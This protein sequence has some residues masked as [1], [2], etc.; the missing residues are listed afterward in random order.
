MLS[1]I[2]RGFTL[3]EL[4]VVIVIL[5]I[6]SVTALPKFINLNQEAER[7]VFESYY[8]A[9]K[10]AVKMYSLSW[11]AKGQPSS[12]FNGFSS[13]PSATGYPAGG[14]NL[15]TVFESDCITIWS[16]LIQGSPPALG[17]I[18]ANNGWGGS[19]SNEDW[20]SNAS[21]ITVLGETE[22]IYC[23]FVYIAA[24]NN[25]SLSGQSGERI[26][27]IQYNIK[28]GNLANVEWPFN[29]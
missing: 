26:S 3:I 22:D 13:I 18:T 21:Q 12:S 20:V 15:N 6:L 27:A 5:G 16:D 17:F 25:G 11:Q 7:A 28:T 9:L 24:Y 4:V 23:H 19:I 10:S 29:P 2:N 8:G 14:S 1:N